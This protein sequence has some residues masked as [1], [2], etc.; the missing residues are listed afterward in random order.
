[1]IR[2]LLY[3]QGNSCFSPVRTIFSHAEEDLAVTK[4]PWKNV[5]QPKKHTYQV[6]E[7]KMRVALI[8]MVG[9]IKQKD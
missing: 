5:L 2:Y 1:M 7:W 8:E 9:V 4:C 6:V 3:L